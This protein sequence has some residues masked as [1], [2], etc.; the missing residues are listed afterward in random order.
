MVVPTEPRPTGLREKKREATRRAIQHA[1]LELATER[2]F[3]HVT[4]EEITAAAHVSPRTFFNYFPSK[5]EAAV[6]GFPQLSE[7]R[8]S[9]NFLVEG[10]GQDI[11]SGL[12]RLF[13][14][15]AEALATDLIVSQRR[16]ELL[17]KHP[18]LF[19]K[20]MAYLHSFEDEIIELV[21]ERLRTDNPE[22]AENADDL[23]LRASLLSQIGLSAMRVAYR[24]WIETSGPHTLAERIAETFQKLD[25]L[26]DTRGRS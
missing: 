11:I 3:E 21:S 7:L 5:E 18:V 20:R 25:V 10:P 23:L 15:A 26:L 6:G 2:G 22:R 4:V 13:E 24:L 9:E 1:V 16:R 12:G 8:A 17:R 19:A 14:A